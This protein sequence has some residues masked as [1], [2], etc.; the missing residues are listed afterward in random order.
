MLIESIANNCTNL[1]CLMLAGIKRITDDIAIAI[2]HH[3]HALSHLSF[4]SCQI[5][6][7][8]IIEVTLW[9]NKLSMIALS[10]NHELTDK[11]IISLADNCPYIEEVYVSGCSMITKAAIMYL[12]VIVLTLIE[13]LCILYNMIIIIL[14]YYWWEFDDW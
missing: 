11:S 4:R 12:Q 3:C 6:D 1:T 14:I 9:C 10:G 2:A 8:G 7:I 13:S 5:S